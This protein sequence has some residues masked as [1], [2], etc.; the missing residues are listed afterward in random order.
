MGFYIKNEESSSFFA[1]LFVRE[2][3]SKL[4]NG[5]LV[6]VS[7]ASLTM[8]HRVCS[9]FVVSGKEIGFSFRSG[10]LHKSYLPCAT[11][12]IPVGGG[13][14]ERNEYDLVLAAHPSFGSSFLILRNA[15]EGVSG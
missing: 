8:K 3:C 1:T 6:R 13:S 14:Y 10:Q 7:L 11:V 5:A 15:Q 2:H 4:R 9:P 12:I